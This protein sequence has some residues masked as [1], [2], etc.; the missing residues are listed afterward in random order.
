MCRWKALLLCALLAMTSIAAALPSALAEGGEILDGRWLC[1]NIAGNVTE[2]TPAEL[3]DDFGLYVNKPWILQTEF[4][5]GVPTVSA[6][7]EIQ[8]GVMDRLFALMKD[9]SLTGHDAEL[10]HKLYAMTGDWDYRNAQG[11]SPVLPYMQAIDGIDSLDALLKYL[12]S[13][14]RLTCTVPFNAYI[15]PCDNADP[16]VYVVNVEPSVLLLGEPEEYVE[17]SE[18]GQAV[19]DHYR[20]T[21]G[22]M[23]ARLGRSESEIDSMLDNAIAFEALLAT[24]R[25]DMDLDVAE[26]EYTPEALSELAGSFP[27]LDVLKSIDCYS[28]SSYHVVDPEYITALQT[29][30]T[31]EN[32]P[33]IRNWLAIDAVTNIMSLLD[34][35]AALRLMAINTSSMGGSGEVNADLSVFS[36]MSELLPVPLDNLYIQTYCTPQQRQNIIDIINE[37]LAAYRVMLESEDWLSEQTRAAAVEKLDALRVHA[38]YPEVLG[39]WSALDFAG[40]ED[41]GSLLEASRT[42]NKYLRMLKASKIG[43][44]ANSITWDQLDM[45][46]Y[47]VNGIYKPSKND[48]TITAGILGGEYYNE[49]MSYEQMLGGIGMIIGHEITHAFDNKGA[50]YDKNGAMANWWTDE[51]YAAF[52]SRAEKLSDWYD[53]FIP[54]EGIQYSGKQVMREVIPDLGSM[55]CMLSIAAQKENFDYDA[56]F[57]QWAR[58]MRAKSS[59]EMVRESVLYDSH[60]L[61]Y[62]RINATLA[63]FEAFVDF[64]GIK[65][66]DGMYIAPEDR[67][68]IW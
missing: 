23:L 25:T 29:V 17:R 27:I 58:A 2:D 36:T 57:R 21:A 62:M 68:E 12:C 52:Q 49:D 8:M 60:P 9:G 48:I 39:D 53:G 24:C 47:T 33:L 55:K 4:T 38:V 41:G 67:L 64:Y 16:A 20:Q 26:G 66:G 13:E 30:F 54:C 65:D 28:D 5:A 59:L 56:F 31:E 19:Y 6:H 40:P 15:A 3:K 22:Y 43:T 37:I 34:E 10:V 45:T 1:S 51:D 50:N 7:S 61:E 35:E 44:V 11:L 14:E 18:Y 32:V 42:I 46:A 63:Q